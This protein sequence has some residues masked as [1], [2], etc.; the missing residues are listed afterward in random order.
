MDVSVSWQKIISIFE[1]HFYRVFQDPNVVKKT[2]KVY[3][4]N[5]VKVDGASKGWMLISLIDAM[6]VLLDPKLKATS[7]KR[8]FNAQNILIEAI[9]I[10]LNESF[11]NNI[12]NFKRNFHQ[13]DSDM[14][15]T[16]MTIF[17]DNN[18]LCWTSFHN[19][20]RLVMLNKENLSQRKEVI[21]KWQDVV[22]YVFKSLEEMGPL[23]LCLQRLIEENSY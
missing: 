3:F 21:D 23:D 15:N 10:V 1:Y 22:D 14:N 17:L 7:K 9:N 11:H 12:N 16:M 20:K 6:L 13:T 19:L 4:S 5:N 18:D 2:K 8:V